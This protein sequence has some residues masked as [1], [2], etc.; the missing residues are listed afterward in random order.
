MR[1]IFIFTLSFLSF[2]ASGQSAR[3]LNKQLKVEYAV[4]VKDYNQLFDQ[5]DSLFAETKTKKG[6]FLQKKKSA[7]QELNLTKESIRVCLKN[8]DRLVNLAF[9]K[10]IAFTRASIE[11]IQLPDLRFPELLVA[12]KQYK[13]T[14][15]VRTNY[16]NSMSSKKIKQQNSEYADYLQRLKGDTSILSKALNDFNVISQLYQTYG[17]KYD[18]ISKSLK[19]QN[20][21]LSLKRSVLDKFLQQA[22]ANYQS[23]G[24]KG[25]NEYYADYFPDVFP[26]E[27]DIQFADVTATSGDFEEAIPIAPV[28][29]ES[30]QQEGPIIY[31]FVDEIAE[32]PGGKAEMIAY[33]ATNIKYPENALK[34]GLQGK[35]YLRF[36]VSENGYISNVK[37]MRGVPDCPEC[38]KE[39]IRVVKS[40]PNWIPGKLNG[41]AVNSV[42]N[43]PVAFKL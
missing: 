5:Y 3:K 32:F 10:D 29:V 41:K 22:R 36:I 35:C 9:T 40:M 37:V 6:A 31:D 18:S 13:M 25:F 42:F 8:Y 30:V 2:F 4:L 27:K 1:N 19:D 39:A 15:L 7:E 16:P 12:D 26:T 28:K 24:P 17:P 43:L 23:K 21:E 33:L 20:D 11:T 38:D 14:D 34:L